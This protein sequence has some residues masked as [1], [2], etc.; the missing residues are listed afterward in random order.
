MLAFELAEKN[1]KIAVVQCLKLLNQKNPDIVKDNE[2]GTFSHTNM[3]GKTRI[4]LPCISFKDY[5]KNQKE[6]PSAKMHKCIGY[7]V[8]YWSE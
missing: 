5:E 3:R 8:L 1:K 7:Y 6:F 4:F 2:D